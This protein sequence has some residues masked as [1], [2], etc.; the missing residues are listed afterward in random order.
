[1]KRKE[2][3]LEARSIGGQEGWVI[4]CHPDLEDSF[5]KVRIDAFDEVWSDAGWVKAND[6]LDE[7]G[8]PASWTPATPAGETVKPDAQKNAD[9]KKEV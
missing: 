1:M 5:Q 7:N 4:M 9:P 2:A 6:L 8:D 3:E